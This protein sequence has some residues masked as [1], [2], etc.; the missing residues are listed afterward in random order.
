[1]QNTKS[2]RFISLVLA[3]GVLVIAGM[4]FFVGPLFKK[5]D[6]TAKCDSD[7]TP[8][9]AVIQNAKITPENT[10][11]TKCDTLTIKNND[12]VTRLMA[13]GQHEN[14]VAYDGVSEKRLEPGQS[15]TIKLNQTGTF[16]FHDHYDESVSA[17][18]TV[19]Q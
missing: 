6:T 10:Q 11:A 16:L 2:F 8:H 17:N 13:F 19:K 7:G 9:V 3:A 1:M 4:I 12:T 18:F 14:H 15:L 5:D